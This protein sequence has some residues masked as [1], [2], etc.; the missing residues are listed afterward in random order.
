MLSSVNKTPPADTN[1]ASSVK[2]NVQSGADRFFRV[3]PMS[4]KCL[5]YI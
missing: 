5:I 2:S 3:K 4:Y 1:C